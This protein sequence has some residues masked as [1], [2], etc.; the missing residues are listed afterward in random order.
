M[1]ELEVEDW[2]ALGK[3]RDSL[4]WALRHKTIKR[5]SPKRVDCPIPRPWLRETNQVEGA[6]HG[7]G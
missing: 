5:V 4:K 7:R 2:E 1:V 3:L 6:V